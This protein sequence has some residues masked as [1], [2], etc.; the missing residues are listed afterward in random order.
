MHSNG[1]NL[2]RISIASLLVAHGIIT[3]PISVASAVEGLSG[4]NG[5]EN[6]I[7]PGNTLTVG[8]I[9]GILSLLFFFQQ[10]GTNIVGSSFGPIMLIWFLMLAVLGISQLTHY[11]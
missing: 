9:I 10:F 6:L 7:A 8:I 1:K 11:P 3:P 5:L 2:D 4:V